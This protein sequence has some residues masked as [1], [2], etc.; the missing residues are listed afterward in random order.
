MTATI[1]PS[2]RARRQVVVDDIAAFLL[3]HYATAGTYAETVEAALAYACG[4]DMAEVFALGILTGHY[5]KSRPDPD[6]L[7]DLI[8]HLERMLPAKATSGPVFEGIPA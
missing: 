4:L 8:E 7:T 5:R 1:S 2:H 6:T 3:Q